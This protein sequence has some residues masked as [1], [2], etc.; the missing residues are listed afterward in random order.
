MVLNTEFNLGTQH[1]GYGPGS[2][3]DLKNITQFDNFNGNSTFILST[4]F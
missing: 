4:S 2:L 3:K 1:G